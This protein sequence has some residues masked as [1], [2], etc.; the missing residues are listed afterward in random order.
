MA[1]ILGYILILAGIALFILNFSIV[2]E[3]INLPFLSAL[4]PLYI[5]IIGAV[6][7]VIGLFLSFKGSAR[8]QKQQEVPIYEGKNIIGYRRGK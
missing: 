3:K 1:K 5:T 8:K 7:I 4:K 2:K 6:L